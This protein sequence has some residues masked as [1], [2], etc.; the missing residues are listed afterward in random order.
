MCSLTVWMFWL[1]SSRPIVVVSGLNAAALMFVV[2]PVSDGEKGNAG[3]GHGVPFG[4][5]STWKV[6]V[7]VAA[8]PPDHGVNIALVV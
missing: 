1:P 4:P 8:G 3:P 7:L 5:L 6:E 2:P